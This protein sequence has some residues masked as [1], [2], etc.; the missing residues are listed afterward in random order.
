MDIVDGHSLINDSVTADVGSP[1]NFVSTLMATIGAF[2]TTIGVYLNRGYINFVC[3]IFST[4]LI[5]IL[6]N[7]GSPIECS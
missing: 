1:T 3:Y 2:S 5:E 7:R 4:K 6:L